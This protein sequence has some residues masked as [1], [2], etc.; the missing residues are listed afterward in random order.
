MSTKTPDAGRLMSVLDENKLTFSDAAK[1]IPGRYG[2]P[3]RQSLR[4]W[5]AVGILVNGQRVKLEARRVGGTWWTSKEAVARFI[6]A[7]NPDNVPPEPIR[8]PAAN[9]RAAQAAGKKLAARGL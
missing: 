2:E 4:R 1:L 9:T 6:D 3:T 7:M 8:S 5:A